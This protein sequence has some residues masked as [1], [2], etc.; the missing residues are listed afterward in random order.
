M[1]ALNLFRKFIPRVTAS[2]ILNDGNLRMLSSF[3]ASA[4]NS[5]SEG[6]ADDDFDVVVGRGSL[7]V[8]VSKSKSEKV[9]D[10]LFRPPAVEDVTEAV[11]STRDGGGRYGVKRVCVEELPGL[12]FEGGGCGCCG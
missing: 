3:K 11:S 9:D 6:I 12:S 10:G 1:L 4:A 8:K 2:S 5:P 7:K